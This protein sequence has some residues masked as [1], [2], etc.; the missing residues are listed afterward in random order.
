[1][2]GNGMFRY[3]SDKYD[4]SGT[5]KGEYKNYKLESHENIFQNV[6]L[7]NFKSF[8]KVLDIVSPDVVLNCSGI[9]KQKSNEYNEEEHRYLNSEIPFLISDLTFKKNFRLINFSTDCVFDGLKGSYKDDDIP[10]AQDIYGSSKALGEVRKA[11]CL[12]I[13]TSTIGLEIDNKHGLLEWFLDQDTKTIQGYEN[14]IYSGLTT[15]ELA[16]YLDHIL[17]N[18]QDLWGV[19]NMASEKI[20]KY[21]LLSILSEKLEYCT[22]V[23]EKNMDFICDR[24][25]DGRLL[26]NLTEFKASNWEKMLS[27]LAIEINNR[28]KNEQNLS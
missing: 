20:S 3:F 17:V 12:T 6:D 11:N 4:V 5:L 13:R 24:S 2:I 27:D 18:F 23:V 8:V 16:K 9:I 22:I 21:K 28:A 15:N 26:D 14:A 19:Y 7:K 1:M 10:N 25:L